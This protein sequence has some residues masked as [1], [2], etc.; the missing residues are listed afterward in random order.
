MVFGIGRP[1]EPNKIDTITVPGTVGCMGLVACP[2]VRVH[3]Q[4]G[5]N[6]KHLIADI[7][8]L[9]EWGVNGIV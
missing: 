9:K 4:T 3:Q 7:E 1:P 5:V 8:A 6:R 2:G